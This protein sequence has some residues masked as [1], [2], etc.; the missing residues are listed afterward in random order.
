M[1]VS[2][3]TVWSLPPCHHHIGPF[4]IREWYKK[5]GSEKL[6]WKAINL[7]FGEW[8]QLLRLQ[9]NVKE[10]MYEIRDVLPHDGD[11]IKKIRDIS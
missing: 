6:S 7:R 10:C 11:Q 2:I 9:E 8:E 3:S 5:D 4:Y 1:N